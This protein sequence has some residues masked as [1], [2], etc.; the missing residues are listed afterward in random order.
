[1]QIDGS[2]TDHGPPVNGR[3]GEGL[4]RPQASYQCRDGVDC[5]WEAFGAVNVKGG[6]EISNDLRLAT[7]RS[8]SNGLEKL[9]AA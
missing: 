7:D 5:R 1:M 6:G 4:Q 8:S 3:G 2:T 9:T